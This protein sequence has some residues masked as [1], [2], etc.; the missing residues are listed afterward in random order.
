[1]VLLTL[2]HNKSEGAT[3]SLQHCFPFDGKEA[4]FLMQCVLSAGHAE[5]LLY[6]QI[7]QMLHDNILTFQGALASISPHPHS[8]SVMS[9]HFSVK[10]MQDLD[11]QE[12]HTSWNPQYLSFFEL[13]CKKSQCSFSTGFLS[14]GLNSND[15][16]FC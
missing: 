1:M 11:M 10:S 7:S 15:T 16:L 5:L 6:K 12:N 2:E 14:A 3:R 8:H 13:V 4:A 9:H